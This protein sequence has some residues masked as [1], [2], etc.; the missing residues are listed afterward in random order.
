MTGFECLSDI[1]SG[2]KQ[3]LAF[4]RSLWHKVGRPSVLLELSTQSQ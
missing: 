1:S 3:A 4:D 2:K